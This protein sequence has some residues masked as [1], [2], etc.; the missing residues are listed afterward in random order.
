MAHHTRINGAAYEVSE[1]KT[2]INGTAFKIEKGRTLVDGTGYDISFRTTCGSLPVGSIIPVNVG[3]K[4]IDFIVIQNGLPG[5]MYDN[6]CDGTWLLMKNVYETRRWHSANVNNYA[7]SELHTYLNNTF[8]N[9]FDSNLRGSI[10]QVKI[11][12]RAGSGYGKTVTSGGN[13]LSTKIFLLSSEEV[14][15]RHDY[16]PTGEGA[17]LSYFKDCAVNGADSKRTS[18]LG[19]NAVPW[20]LR[21][22]YCAADKGAIMA[23]RVRADGYWDYF[24]CD[25]PYGLR[26]AFILPSD[27]VIEM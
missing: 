12:H 11:P 14:G 1:G 3:G 22:P 10:K 13:G 27:F 15:F 4:L 18:Y 19:G 8:L 9:L 20:W 5:A 25:T 16:M 24:Y 17:T 6:S 23:L 7:A 2:L 26:P 21:S